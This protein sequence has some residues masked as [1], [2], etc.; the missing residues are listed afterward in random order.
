MFNQVMKEFLAV[1]IQ[2]KNE[3]IQEIQ[4]ILLNYDLQD[5]M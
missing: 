1:D 2:K 5:H 3:S 4:D